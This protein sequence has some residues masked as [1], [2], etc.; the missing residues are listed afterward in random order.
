M[1]LSSNFLFL[2]SCS[3][4]ISASTTFFFSSSSSKIYSNKLCDAGH[5][6][7]LSHVPF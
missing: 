7:P 4:S 5:L 6:I 2:F 3:I 1:K